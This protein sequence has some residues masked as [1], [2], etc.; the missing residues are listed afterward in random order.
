MS[1][2]GREETEGWEDIDIEVTEE[3]VF[4]T[5]GLFEGYETIRWSLPAGPALASFGCVDSCESGGVGGSGSFNGI[6]GQNVDLIK[7][8]VS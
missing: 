8:G 6:E 7:G 1:S 3:F 5:C 2:S 4:V